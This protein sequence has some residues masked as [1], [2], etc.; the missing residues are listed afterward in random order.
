MTRHSRRDGTAYEE[1]KEFTD[2]PLLI[3]SLVLIPVLAVPYIW[4][5]SPATETALNIAAVI[6]W[7]L[8]AIEYLVLFVLAPDRWHMVRTHLFD[9]LIIVVPFL[10]PLRAARS[11]RL[12]RL[13]TISGRVGVGFKAVAGR[14]GTRFFLLGVLGVVVVGAILTYAFEDNAPGTNIDT[15]GDALWWAI[16]TTT[17]VG[18]GDYYPVTSQG[19]V[20]ASALMVVGIGMLGVVTANIAAFFVDADDADDQQAL[21]ER[22]DRLEALVLALSAGPVDGQSGS[23]SGKSAAG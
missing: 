1:F 21:I 23:P 5:V 8:F 20:V 14:R 16:V 4:D 2:V 7:A 19:R 9:L 12:L 17:T 13:L 10:R 22:L 6:I 3:A 15:F 11:A 18:Y